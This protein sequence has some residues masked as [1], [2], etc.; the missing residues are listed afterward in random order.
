[1]D[2]V[3]VTLITQK[4]SRMLEEF[5]S[6]DPRLSFADIVRGVAIRVIAGA[7]RRTKAADAE[8]IKARHEAQEWITLD[9]RKIK[10]S[11]YLHDDELYRRVHNTRIIRLN[12]KLASRGLS[13]KSWLHQAEK[14]GGSI[15][16]PGFVAA[17]NYRGESHP[18]NVL[19]LETSAAGQFALKIINNSPIVQ[20]AGG[21]DALL[22]AMAAETR[23]FYT[24]LARGGFNTFESRSKKYPGVYIRPTSTAA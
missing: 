10:L 24:V 15:K 22:Y 4:F 1:V 20:A 23:Y 16:V 17:A 19:H 13:K 9:D 12:N 18:E 14:L 8:K 2:D 6:I 7:L 3:K 21:R 5:A 11:W